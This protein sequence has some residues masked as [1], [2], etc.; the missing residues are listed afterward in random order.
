MAHSKGVIRRIRVVPGAMRMRL[1][2]L[3]GSTAIPLILCGCG[4]IAPPEDLTAGSI[5]PGLGGADQVVVRFVNLTQGEAVDVE[6]FASPTTLGVLPDDLF[7]ESN[8]LVTSIGVAGTGIVEPQTQDAI[9]LPCVDGMVLGTRGGRFVEVESG[10]P[11]GTG[12]PR[13][14][15]QAPL[16]LCGGMVSFEFGK[17]GDSFTTVVR[18]QD[19]P[20]PQPSSAAAIE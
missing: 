1:A 15:A 3:L 8:R 4:T 17:V 13:W 20:P 10:E 6:F 14:L 19:W 16:G 11:R 7:Q 2:G 9:A 12:V 5:N 18:I